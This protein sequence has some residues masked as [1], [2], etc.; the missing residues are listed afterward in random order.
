MRRHGS[1]GMLHGGACGRSRSGD[2]QRERTCAGASGRLVPQ[3]ARRPPPYLRPNDTQYAIKDRTKPHALLDYMQSFDVEPGMP[4][5]VMVT[6]QVNRSAVAGNYSVSVAVRDRA[7]RL[8]VAS[9]HL[10]V[11]DFALPKGWSLPSLFGAQPQNV[12]GAN[13]RNTTLNEGQAEAQFAEM[14][15]EHRVPVTSLYGHV[16]DEGAPGDWQLIYSEGVEGI[17]RLWERGQRTWNLLAIS[18]GDYPGTKPNLTITRSQVDV[19]LKARNVS[20]AAG[21]PR[22]LT[23]VCKC[24]CSLF[25]SL[26]HSLKRLL[27]RCVRRTGFVC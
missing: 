12:W 24:S 9:I 3:C 26:S 10:T 23:T 2:L 11:W 13:S 6:F 22:N 8:A 27:H 7:G 18:S 1:V 14:L 5:P 17:K 20:D 15:L 4:Q 25:G 16:P 21:W 19:I